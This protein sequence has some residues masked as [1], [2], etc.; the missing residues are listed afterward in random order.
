VFVTEAPLDD[1]AGSVSDIFPLYNYSL[2]DM[3]GD[4]DMDMK[5]SQ[6]RGRKSAKSSQKQR[7]A[8]INNTNTSADGGLQKQDS[9]EFSVSS[10][11]QGANAVGSSSSVA[12]NTQAS[13]NTQTNTL[14]NAST[15]SKNA[16]SVGSSVPVSLRPPGPGEWR[17]E[18]SD[19]H[20]VRCAKF[21][22]FEV[23]ISLC[24]VCWWNGEI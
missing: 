3:D 13:G 20:P 17:R 24:S 12:N 22:R 9:G 11:Q 2:M 8:P 7:L 1:D 19:D 18:Y 5:Q 6:S 21:R 15:S 23:L 10:G 16:A 4:N 14:A